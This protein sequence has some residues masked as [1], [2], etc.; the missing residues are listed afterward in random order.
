MEAVASPLQLQPPSRSGES[1]A[2]DLTETSV[3]IISKEYTWTL[4]FKSQR[5]FHSICLCKTISFLRI[6]LKTL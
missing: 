2:L 1:D 4:N 6:A 3:L 5:T